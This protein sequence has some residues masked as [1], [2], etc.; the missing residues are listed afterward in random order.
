METESFKR[1][2]PVEEPVP[3][4]A[5]SYTCAKCTFKTEDND[6]LK[7]HMGNAHKPNSKKGFR[8]NVDQNGDGSAQNRKNV[9]FCHHWN[10]FGSCNF[11]SKNGRPC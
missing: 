6:R 9:L 7:E 10:N 5:K 8:F 1:T 4:N 3:V 2:S 11:E